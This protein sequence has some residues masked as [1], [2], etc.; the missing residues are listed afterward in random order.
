MATQNRKTRMYEPWG[1][2]EENNYQSEENLLINDIDSFFVGASYNSDDKKIHFTNKDGEEKATID[3]TEFSSSVIESVSYDKTT[4]ILTIKFSNGDVIE[5]NVAELIDESEFT[6]GL[7][8]VDGIV[9][10]LIDSSGESYL[11]VSEDGLKISGVNE[12]IETA[13][14]AEKTRAEGVESGFDDR[15]SQNSVAISENADAIRSNTEAIQANAQSIASEASRAIEAENTLGERI[16]QEIN[17][18]IADVDAE[19]TRAKA[20]ENVLQNNIDA[21]VTRA[22]QTEQGLNHRIDLV[23][24]ELDSEES[25]R[26]SNDAALSLRITQEVNDRIADVN[27]EEARAQ[28]AETALQSAIEAEGQ[29][30]QDAENE[31]NVSAFF[32]TDYDD[33]AKTI[34]F[35]NK[36]DVLLTSIDATPFIKDGMIDSVYIDHETEELVIVWNTESGKQETRISLTEIFNPDDYYTKI[37]VDNFLA[38]KVDKEIIGVNGKALIF[39]ESDGGGAKFEHNDGTWSFAGVNDGGEDGIAG[40][41]YALKK[42]ASNKFE[43]ARI[44]VTKNG[45]YYTVGDDSAVIRDVEANEIAT[46]GDIEAEK[47]RAIATEE[48]LDRRIDSV[49]SGSTEKINELIEK[50]GYKDNDTLETS[51]EFEVAFGKYNVTNTDVNPSGKTIFSIGIGV[52][53]SERKNALEVRENGDVYMLVEGDYLQI[54]DL[55][56]MLAHETYDD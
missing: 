2:Q 56:G 33:E 12:A 55:L 25:T 37:E 38:K 45:M 17:D 50:L 15:I 40:Q 4:K 36:N 39:N 47:N 26:E 30:A 54:N 41:I 34:N 3:V 10:I 5:I 51:N 46:K 7:Q 42:N 19:E 18:R 11:S 43:G 23:N 49:D 16:T 13:V 24:D 6:D 52:S 8:V 27:A 22:T 32:N 35:Y 53:E 31:I 29:R 14:E 20:A 9:S 44:D 28:S 21:E 48:A 1:Y